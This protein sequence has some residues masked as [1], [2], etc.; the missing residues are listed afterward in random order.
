VP[1][2]FRE[3]KRINLTAK[4]AKLIRACLAD[5]TFNDHYKKCSLDP[6]GLTL[7][8]HQQNGNLAV[9]RLVEAGIKIGKK[10]A[11]LDVPC[12]YSTSDAEAHVQVLDRVVARLHAFSKNMKGQTR[13]AFLRA[14]AEIDAYAHRNAMQ[15]LAEAVVDVE[16]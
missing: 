7:C 14:A 11:T 15:V 6:T 12:P 4:T 2:R 8:S 9:A 1:R 16:R 3:F 13:A 10:R 5:K